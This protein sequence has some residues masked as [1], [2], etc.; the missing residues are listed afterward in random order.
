VF[1][2]KA[3][4]APAHWQNAVVACSALSIHDC[5]GRNR[6]LLPWPIANSIVPTTYLDLSDYAFVGAYIAMVVGIGFYLRRRAST[7]LDEYLVG[8]RAVPWWMLGISGVMDFWDLAGTMIIVSF[9]YLLGPRGLFIEFRGGAV[10]VLAVIMLWTG[11]WHRR[12]G[13]LTAGEWMIYRFGDGAAGRLAQ[14]TR[15]AAG[16]VVIVG[17]F[18]YLAKGAGLFLASFVPF[19]P[20]QCAMMLLATSAV[21]TMFAGFRGVVA[22]HIVQMGIILMAAAMIIYLGAERLAS[23][24]SLPELAERVTGNEHWISAWPDAHT[25]MPPGY[26]TYEPLM[27]FA[28]LYLLRNVLF[29]LG[30]GDDPKYFGARSDADCGKLTLLWICLI[31]IRWPMML[32]IAILGLSLVDRLFP[33]PNQPQ[34]IAELIQTHASTSAEEWATET[35]RLA[36]GTAADSDRLSAELQRELGEN[37]QAKLLLVSYYGTID[38]E[39]IMPAVLM[40][41]IPAGFRSLILVSLLA[42]AMATSSAWINQASGFFV[43][44]IYQKHVRPAA[45]IRELL[46]ATWLFI[47]GLCVVGFVFAFSAKNINDIWA[48]IIMGLGGGMIFPQLLPLYWSRFNGIGYSVGTLSGVV[49]A[50][51]LRLFGSHLPTQWAFISSEG[52]SLVILGTI[53]LATGIIATYA[54]SPTPPPVLRNFY[55]T[56]LPFGTWRAFKAMLPLELQHRVSAEHTRDVASLPFALAFQISIFLAPMLVFVGN[57]M[58]LAV[59]V[60]MAVGSIAALYA[61][62]LRHI[63]ES[64]RIVADA[65]LLAANQAAGD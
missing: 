25:T 3:Y 58:A 46:A 11:K 45:G 56:T 12:S 9:L 22:T 59:S 38:P 21:Y 54:S 64:D 48:W 52:W 49:A 27:L 51:G 18:A 19:T 31:S 28:G 30:A 8:A 35:S 26:K 36:F 39:R 16:I 15:A 13:C 10:L 60:V 23:I 61:I 62:W 42:A 4:Y 6:F 55:L 47:A 24:D 44:D 40:L 32:C 33:D 20:P 1:A 37:W 2:A 53:G 14:F 7:S 50:V 17:L 5:K 41:S 29:G 65:R 57:Q 63:H 43:R 34:R